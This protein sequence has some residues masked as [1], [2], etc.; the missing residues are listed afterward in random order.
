MKWWAKAREDHLSGSLA[1]MHEMAPDTC[2]RTG[3][4]PTAHSPYEGRVRRRRDATHPL[5]LS[6]PNGIRFFLSTI[7]AATSDPHIPHPPFAHRPRRRTSVLFFFSSLLLSPLRFA[8]L[9][10]RLIGR[11][12]APGDRERAH[13]LSRQGWRAINGCRMA[14]SR[15]SRLFCCPRCGTQ[16]HSERRSRM[17]NRSYHS[18]ELGRASHTSVILSIRAWVRVRVP[19]RR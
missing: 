3:T 19:Y 13:M 12:L 5:A 17:V 9:P 11:R 4:E 10:R 8:R 15:L 14:W 2:F 1:Q 16:A 6:L 18:S 7:G